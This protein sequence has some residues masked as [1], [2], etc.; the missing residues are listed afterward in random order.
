MRKK[1][2]ISRW[3]GLVRSASSN[4]AVLV[5][6]RERDTLVTYPPLQRCGPAH[7]EVAPES[8]RENEPMVVVLGVLHPTPVPGAQTSSHLEVEARLGDVVACVVVQARR[9]DVLVRYARAAGVPRAVRC[10]ISK[11]AFC[12]RCH[13]G[14]S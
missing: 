8:I 12:M 14:A 7:L 3:P 6:V 1:H 10:D 9:D 4:D 13:C 11:T 5:D 2:R